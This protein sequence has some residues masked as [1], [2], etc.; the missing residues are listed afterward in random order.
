V[1]ANAGVASHAVATLCNVAR[2]EQFA[3]LAYCFMPDHLHLVVEGTDVHWDL[4]RFTARAKQQIGFELRAF[5]GGR[6]WQD[7]YYERVL[8][9]DEDTNAIVRY[10]L[11]NPVR[12]GLA[13]A[14]GE[15]PHA[16]TAVCSV[17]ELIP[18]WDAG[19]FRG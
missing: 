16:G 6:L 11:E 13:R 2:R 19:R 5:V 17:R 1:F 9:A 12:A 14:I 18:L 8:R 10:V 4:R 3:V 7:G 15:Y